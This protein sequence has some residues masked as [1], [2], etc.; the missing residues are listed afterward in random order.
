MEFKIS[1][2][3]MDITPAI[4]TYAGKKTEKL[5]RF[6]DR[7]QSITAVIDRRERDFELEL[8]VD[9]EHADPIIARTDHDDLYACIDV[10]VDK[11]ERQLVDHKQR[12]RNR[13][14]S[15]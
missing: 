14:H 5:H 11:V 13:K 2:R 1:G 15:A 6:Y 9:V 10:T 8:I 4:E 12:L 3:H 7:I